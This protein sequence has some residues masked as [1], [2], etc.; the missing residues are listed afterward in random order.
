MIT[1]QAYK[2][3]AQVQNNDKIAATIARF[4]KSN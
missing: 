3:F 4:W 1:Y 2:I